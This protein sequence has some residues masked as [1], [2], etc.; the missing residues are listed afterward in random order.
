MQDPLTVA[1]EIRRPWPRRANWLTETAKRYGVRWQIRGGL[2]L[3]GRGYWWPD[4]I[5]VWHRDPSGY[6]DRVCPIGSSRWRLHVHHWRVQVHPFQALRRWLL[7]RCEAC[8]GPSRR[9]DEVDFSRQWDS[10]KSPW[11]RGEKGVVHGRCR[12]PRKN[13]R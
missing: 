10:P 9:G 4:F 12:N 1:F 5:T 8:G 7:T 3:A 13:P 2:I 11:W 6:D